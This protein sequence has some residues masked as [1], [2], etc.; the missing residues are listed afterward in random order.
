MSGDI[1]HEEDVDAAWSGI[2]RQE[3]ALHDLPQRITERP[4]PLLPG[5]PNR[6]ADPPE[7]VPPPL[8][9]SGLPFL[10]AGL[11][12]SLIA[13]FLLHS[14]MAGSQQGQS[15]QQVVAESPLQASPSAQAPSSKQLSPTPWMQ[16]KPSGTV[17]PSPPVPSVLLPLPVR[18]EFFRWGVGLGGV[19]LLLTTFGLIAMLMRGKKL[20][21]REAEIKQQEAVRMATIESIERAHQQQLE[22]W[23]VECENIH[24]LISAE[25]ERVN[26]ENERIEVDVVKIRAENDRL[27]AESGRRW[28]VDVASWRRGCNFVLTQYAEWLERGEERLQEAIS[29]MAG[30]SR[31]DVI[32]F[33]CI[34]SPP[35]ASHPL[36]TERRCEPP[37]A[38]LANVSY[39][40][41]LLSPAA[42]II[43]PRECANV[44]KGVMGSLVAGVREFARDHA[45]DKWNP[46]SSGLNV[47][48]KDTSLKAAREPGCDVIVAA[49][50]VGVIELYFQ[51]MINVEM[52]GGRIA[53][54]MR[55]DR[56]VVVPGDA[57]FAEKVRNAL[58][59]SKAVPKMASAAPAPVAPTTVA[60]ADESKVCPQCAETIKAAAKICRFCRYEFGQTVS[61]N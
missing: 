40:V 51:E 20:A 22:K 45:P 53:I 19:A 31:S 1:V 24:K 39:T 26:A 50:R 41:Y 49:P 44:S 47:C 33:S 32:D 29:D 17:S 3:P 4:R 23:A 52:Q 55:D 14:G 56:K 30:L 21:N 18:V 61:S 38:R 5:R 25:T 54:T 13:A 46:F 48:L 37:D 57:E 16:P 6:T 28:E 27:Q 42:L 60:V 10:I 7:V 59:A 43:A 9:I 2:A 15:V 11:L 36:Q 8:P 58:R 12:L 34:G 35:E